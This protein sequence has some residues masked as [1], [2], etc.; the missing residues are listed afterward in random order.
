MAHMSEPTARVLIR[1]PGREELGDVAGLLGMAMADN[2]NHV[3][4]YR[5]DQ[6]V[7]SSKHALL[8]RAVLGRRPGEVHLGAFHG[9]AVVGFVAATPSPGCQPS[10][11]EMA[12]MLPSLVPLGPVSLA[13]VLAWQRE[14]GRHHPAAAHL[15]I[16]P[17][18]VHPAWRGRGVGRRLLNKV[19]TSHDPTASDLPAYLETDRE[20]NVDFYRAAGFTL[21]SEG[22][23]LGQPNWF[24]E[25]R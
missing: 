6:S 20:V 1:Q 19:I 7:R 21:T 15:H 24:M 25:R 5:G 8:M 10:P 18:A 14:W 12:R 22:A 3:A 17:L 4:A 9:R 16:G 2:P 11:V 23:V 13:R